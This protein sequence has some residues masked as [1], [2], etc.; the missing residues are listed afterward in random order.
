MMRDLKSNIDIVQALA[1]AVRATGTATG[2]AV[3]L[4]GYN[5]AV[6]AFSIGAWTDGTHTPSI[7]DSA[8]GTTYAAAAAADQ[9]GTFTAISGTA[10]Q[11]AVQKVGYVGIKPFIKPMLVSGTSTTGAAAEAFVI[12]GHANQGP[13]A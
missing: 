8:D 12:R 3:P 13:L 1:P 11:N 7:F 5:A 4:Q 10:Q 9:Q 6:V 2:A